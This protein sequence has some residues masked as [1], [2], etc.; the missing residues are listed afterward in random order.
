MCESIRLNCVILAMWET[1]CGVLGYSLLYFIFIPLICLC[2]KQFAIL[3]SIDY[4]H[5]A[6]CVEW[7][8]WWPVLLE[9]DIHGDPLTILPCW[10]SSH[11]LSSWCCWTS[12]NHLP[13]PYAQSPH[14]MPQRN[15]KAHKIYS[16]AVTQRVIWE[17]M[18]FQTD[19]YHG[20]QEGCWI[21]YGLCLTHYIAISNLSG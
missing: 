10:C 3:G 15:L 2:H 9:Q 18:Y 12:K 8:N 17:L 1:L 21:K 11:L 14:L 5:W 16:S 4:L 20:E 13:S 7:C 6:L 19:T